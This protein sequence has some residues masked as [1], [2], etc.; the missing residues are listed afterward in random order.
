MATEDDQPSLSGADWFHVTRSSLRTSANICRSSVQLFA[1]VVV[2]GDV[3]SCIFR[4]QLETCS[5][6]G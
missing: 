6:V 3:F 4:G 1:A 5:T 2:S